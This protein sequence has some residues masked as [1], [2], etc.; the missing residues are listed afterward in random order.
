MNLILK[1]WRQ[2]NAKVKGTFV[3]Y[4]MENVSPEMSFLEML[5]ALN[6]KLVEEDKD[7]VHSI[8]LP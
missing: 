5:D 8:I 4:R 7:P 2:K 3:T 1:I 6:K